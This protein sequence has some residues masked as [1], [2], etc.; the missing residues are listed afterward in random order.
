[1]SPEGAHDPTNKEDHVCARRRD[2][3]AAGPLRR[4]GSDEPW[5]ALRFGT[6]PLT[7]RPEITKAR[8]VD[9]SIKGQ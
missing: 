3:E 9:A 4:H 5:H 7:G 6:R 2:G 1:M 8:G